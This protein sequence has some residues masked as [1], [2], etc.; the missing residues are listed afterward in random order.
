MTQVETVL[1]GYGIRTDEG[2]LGFCGVTLL[3]DG[4]RNLLVDVGHVGRRTLLLERLA[5]LGLTPNDIDAVVLTHAHWDHCLNVDCFPRARIVISPAEHEYTRQPHELDWATPVW[6]HAVLD[7]HP[8]QEVRDGEEIADG[9]TVMATAGHSP[10]SQTVLVR[11]AEGTTGIVGDALPWSG[12]IAAGL[13]DNVFWDEE[14]A[15]ASISRIVERCDVVYPGHDRA[16]RI[17]NG[18]FEY[19]ENTTITFS[20]LPDMTGGVIGATFAGAA[21]RMPAIHPSARRSVV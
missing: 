2:A 6:T 17:R 13:P 12:S 10:G 4:G 8:I 3:R 21:P 14:A 18:S 16:F 5:A 19:I 11:T 20:R 9:V 15:R 1:Q 7:R